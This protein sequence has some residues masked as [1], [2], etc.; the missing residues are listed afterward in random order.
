MD[1]GNLTKESKDIELGLAQLF[2]ENEVLMSA[3][4]D[5]E[6]TAVENHIDEITRQKIISGQYVD[7]AKLIP[8]DKVQISRDTRMELVNRGGRTYYEPAYEKEASMINSFQK[9]QQAFR[10]YTSVFS[11]AHPEKIKELIQY[12]HIIHTASSTYTWD[13]VYAYDIDFRIHMS[14]HPQ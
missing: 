2:K 4:V 9:W 6:Y 7:L 10:V 12:K 1:E 13:N 8:K 3:L 5:E 14:N 11:E